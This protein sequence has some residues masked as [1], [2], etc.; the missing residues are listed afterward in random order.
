VLNF[1]LQAPVTVVKPPV[2]NASRTKLDDAH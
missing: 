1:T 2:P